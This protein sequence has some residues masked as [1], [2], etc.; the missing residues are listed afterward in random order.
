MQLPTLLAGP[1]VRRVER[2]RVCVWLATSIRPSR[3]EL[4]LWVFRTHDRFKRRLPRPE[5][6]ERL[7]VKTTSRT[8]A[9]APKLFVTLLL[10]EPA[11]D[12]RVSTLPVNQLIGYDLE[13][14]SAGP[15]SVWTLASL[16]GQP[17]TSIA[18][19]GFSLPTF[20]IQQLD[21]NTGE[22][23]SLRLLHGSCRKLTAP[24]EDA[25]IA[26]DQVVA[27][28][29]AELPTR[30]AVLMLT[31][32]QI[33]PDDVPMPVRT[34][35][36]ELAHELLGRWETIHWRGKTH[37]LRD[38]TDTDRANLGREVGIDAQRQLFGF[39]EFAAMYLLAWNEKLWPA[40]FPGLDEDTAE[41]LERSRSALPKLRRLFANTPTYMIFDDHEITDGWNF[42]Q[43]W[44]RDVYG[45]ELGKQLRDDGLAAYWAFQHWGN[46]PA[47]F[48]DAFVRALDRRHEER[49]AADR[50]LF[51]ADWFFASA[52][53]PPIVVLDTRTK[54]SKE[55]SEGGPP[56]LLNDDGLDRAAR[57]A[58]EA[59]HRAGDV[60]IVVSAA[61]VFG[62]RSFERDVSA[63]RAREEDAELW[64]NCPQGLREFM[65]ML[66]RDL[67][68]GRVVFLS[69]DR[70]YGFTTE[71]VYWL[72]VGYDNPL[73]PRDP[74]AKGI[75]IAQ[76]VS[77]GL[78]QR[79]QS[80][81][82]SGAFR[83]KIREIWTDEWLAGDRFPEPPTWT[84]FI[85]ILSPRS[86]V[87]RGPQLEPRTNVGLLSLQAAGV[88]HALFGVDDG[89]V[90][91]LGDWEV[92]L[93]RR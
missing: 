69:G 21:R 9:L 1:I 33:Y 27:E 83:R 24:G 87:G 41:A 91:R 63:A 18:Q 28:N 92:A 53:T 17:V 55:Q 35:L 12:S 67:R 60:L 45:T 73:W 71:A 50:L 61:P 52:T 5:R 25:S 14:R 62:V 72:G 76:C 47:K 16:L 19:E 8:V 3:A 20:F 59:G 68:V 30:P 74:G 82:S 32:D 40:S 36:D 70:H 46:A 84:E 77:S 38:L 7:A 66:S 37:E 29:A 4:Q 10:A 49:S 54:R 2:R 90:V 81:A 42:N 88:V 57:V 64:G 39:G 6:G 11:G 85:Q 31:G 93:P 23:L 80:I 79:N 13:L 34:H 65:T 86:G 78:K 43:K 51:L 15:P 58:A 56:R 22:G 75:S 26:A 44:E 89:E 48:D